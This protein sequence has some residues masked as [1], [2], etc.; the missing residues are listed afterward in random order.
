MVDGC[1]RVVGYEVGRIIA[2]GD[3]VVALATAH[4][5]S[6]ATGE[7]HPYSKVDVFRLEDGRIAEFR[8]S[9]GTAAAAARFCGAAR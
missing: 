3:W 6:L 9:F 7:T 4:V 5:Q 8:E 1:A 2:Q